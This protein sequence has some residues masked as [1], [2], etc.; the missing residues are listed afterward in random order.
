MP[1]ATIFARGGIGGSDPFGPPSYGRA[2]RLHTPKAQAPC[3]E[4]QEERFDSIEAVMGLPYG[5]NVRGAMSRTT[6]RMGSSVSGSQR[7]L[8]CV[9]R[10]SQRRRAPSET[11]QSWSGA[12]PPPSRGSAALS[13]TGSALNHIHVP[14]KEQIL[15]IDTCSR[16]AR[17]HAAQSTALKN[18]AVL[19]KV[20]S[21]PNLQSLESSMTNWNDLNDLSD[22]ASVLQRLYN[23]YSK[24]KTPKAR[25]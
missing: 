5:G 16:A 9:S 20:A 17:A 13:H 23:A 4:I 22:G 11:S 21:E 18:R 10:D 3:I 1:S 25:R 15:D 6:S 8:S 24:K 7:S 2:G 12:A 14:I 19:N